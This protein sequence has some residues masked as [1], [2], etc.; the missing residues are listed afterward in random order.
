M[1]GVMGVNEKIVVFGGT[2]LDVFIYGDEPHDAKIIES[3]GG[4]GLNIAFG[5][6]KLG[7]EVE[8]ISNIGNDWKGKQILSQL[9]GYGFNIHGMNILEERTGYHISKEDIPI[10]VDRGVNKLPLRIKKDSIERADIVIINTEIALHSFRE[11]CGNFS[12]KLFIDMGPLFNIRRADISINRNADAIFI[13]N[14][15]MGNVEDFDIIKR[16]ANGASWNDIEIKGNGKEY[17]YKVGAG[18][19][20]DVVFISSLLTGKTERESLENAVKISQDMTKE[21]R[22]A[23]KKVLGLH[24]KVI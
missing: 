12:G 16:G 18:D 24:K 7:F 3:P 5:L 15:N 11:I 4:S 13:G 8:F 14:H 9:R 21:V 10:A 6:F 1:T 2:F 23:F 17:P 19:I 20:F 22:G